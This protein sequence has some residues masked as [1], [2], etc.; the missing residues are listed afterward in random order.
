MH[1][2]DVDAAQL[3]F[4]AIGLGERSAAHLVIEY[5]P[6]NG[7]T[8]RPRM[9]DKWI[10]KATSARANPRQHGAVQ[11][12]HPDDV[13]VQF[14]EHLLRGRGLR[15][16]GYRMGSIVDDHVERPRP[17]CGVVVIWAPFDSMN[18]GSYK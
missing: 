2:C 6:M 1:D 9:L 5:T 7:M 8:V 10:K 12:L 14:V 11:A 3:Q 16:R 13:R 18:R 17:R 15:K 4:T